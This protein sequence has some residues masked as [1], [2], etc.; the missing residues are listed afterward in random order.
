M[1]VSDRACIWCCYI[2]KALQGGKVENNTSV[3]FR[4]WDFARWPPDSEGW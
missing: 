4:E 2:T 1:C 3:A